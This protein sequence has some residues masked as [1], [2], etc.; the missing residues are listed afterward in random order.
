VFEPERY[1]LEM[2]SV[3]IFLLVLT[4]GNYVDLVTFD[5]DSTTGSYNWK[6][7]N[8][9]VMGGKSNSTWTIHKDKKLANWI[10]NCNIVPSLKAP[11]FCNAETTSPFTTT[12]NDASGFTHLQIKMRSMVNYYGMKVSFA[13]NTLMPQFKSFKADFNITSDG[14]WNTVAI[15]FN[16][17]SNDWSP[18]TG[19][20]LKKCSEHPEVCP[21]DKDLKTIETIGF[22]MEGVEGHFEVDIEYVRA[23]YAHDRS[24]VMTSNKAEGNY[25]CHGE[26]QQK[27]KYNISTINWGDSESITEAICC[28]SAYAGFAEPSGLFDQVQLFEG[29]D[30][31]SETTFYDPVCGIP[32]F[33]APRGRTF[34]DWKKETEEHG[35]P[36]FRPKEAVTENLVMRGNVVYSKCGTRLG[37]NLPDDKGARYCLDLSCLAGHPIKLGQSYLRNI[38]SQF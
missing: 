15:P 33:H 20:P 38:I 16:H 10:G 32:L 35:W 5:G 8:D 7:V 28:D 21:T 37:D 4:F 19:E 25:T 34:D 3:F 13:A 2:F 23:G 29:I 6:L 14:T 27:L 36:S 1:I 30:K 24:K 22:W 17:F 11:G 26:I 18:A 9:P 31:K 12:F